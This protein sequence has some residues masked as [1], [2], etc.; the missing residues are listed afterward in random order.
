M[1]NR[2]LLSSYNIKISACYGPRSLETVINHA[3]MFAY[4]Q[5]VMTSFKLDMA[6]ES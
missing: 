6:N 3:D 4:L 5:F 2:D 1:A